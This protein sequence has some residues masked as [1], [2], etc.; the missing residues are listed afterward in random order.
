MRPVPR[1]VRP[2]PVTHKDRDA[3]RSSYFSL[4]E[5][6]AVNSRPILVI[7]GIA[8]GLALVVGLVYYFTEY[9]RNQALAAYADAY[10]KYTATVGASPATP[11][12]PGQPTVSFPDTQTKFREAAAAFEKLADDYSGYRDIGRYYA[13]LSY[14]ENGDD[15]GLALLQGIADG[16]S[17]VANEARLALA[18]QYLKR[19]DHANAES[20][21]TKLVEDPK[22]LPSSFL[23][24]R[25]GLVK[26]R[27]TKPAE[28]AALY[29]QVVDTDRTSPAGIEAE[30]GLQRV[31]PKQAASLPPKAPP[32]GPPGGFPSGTFP[33]A[34]GA[35][36]PGPPP[37]FG[38]APPGF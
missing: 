35:P 28:A 11:A 33:G 7:G 34:G 13:G 14:L 32:A 31:D 19:G 29:R 6:V 1:S 10:S 37:G 36:T 3:F 38:G 22:G 20:L 24:T 16:D 18:E 21:Y 8:V 2:A 23:K 17:E 30:K 25:L 15:K 5:W 9:R 26:E 12:M 27:L 4:Q